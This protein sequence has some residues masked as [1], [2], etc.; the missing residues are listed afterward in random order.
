MTVSDRG[1]IAAKTL[2]R[3][4]VDPESS[5]QH[6]FHAGRLRSLLGFT[7]GRIEGRLTILSY[8]EDGAEPL[9]DEVNFT[10]YDAR[11]KKPPRSEW[12][13]YY[14]TGVIQQRA[15]EGDLLVLF[16]APSAPN[17]I[18]AVIARA[19][20]S[21]ER[22]LRQAL[23]LKNEGAISRFV[24]GSKKEN[25]PLAL[26]LGQKT[27]GWDW[28]FDFE[29]RK[30]PLFTQAK[31]ASKLPTTKV[32]AAAAAELVRQRF[33]DSLGPDDYLLAALDAESQLFF[34][35]EEATAQTAIANLLNAQAQLTDI[36][37]FAMSKLQARKSRRGRSLENHIQSLFE[38]YGIRFTDQ[39]I[40][41]PGA[42]PDFVIPGC[43]EYHDP[44]YPAHLLRMVGCKSRIRERWP[45]Y[46]KEAGRIEVKYHVSVD[47]DLTS[48][49]VRD[50]HAHKLRLYMPKML[51]DRYYAGSPSVGLI[52]GIEDLIN[53]LRAVSVGIK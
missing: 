15:R 45:Q 24:S 13:L 11:E 5:N 39:C 44:Q 35:V 32:M 50:M 33:G 48:S 18:R 8:L 21:Y 26:D 47:T 38:T 9:I 31:T 10:L 42:R 53:D 36:L 1:A 23:A 16:R 40:T 22:E 49:V 3:V 51:V 34:A 41:E 7:G 37:D 30:H 19:G 14:T 2:S 25:L 28:D 17:E 6:E 46:L 4:E 52:D 27:L 43:L 29:V 12:H 20:T